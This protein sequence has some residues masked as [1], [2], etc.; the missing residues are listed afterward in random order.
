MDA[1]IC[2]SL[3]DIAGNEAPK[4]REIAVVGLIEPFIGH[5]IIEYHEGNPDFTRFKREL[6]RIDFKGCKIFTNETYFNPLIQVITG[7][8]PVSL[9][10]LYLPCLE[11]LKSNDKELPRCIVHANPKTPNE[12]RIT[13]AL[14][15]AC[16]YVHY[17]RDNFSSGEGVFAGDKFL[18]KELIQR[19]QKQKK[20]TPPQRTPRVATNNSFLP[21]SRDEV[22]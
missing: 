3:F 2:I 21:G 7:I 19:L 1:V 15:A 8:T 4:I 5:W 22:G 14:K 6:E 18:G 12:R 11:T 20:E 17:I 13:C 9:G 10:K 16:N